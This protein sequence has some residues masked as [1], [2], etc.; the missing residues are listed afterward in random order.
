MSDIAIAECR[1]LGWTRRVRPASLGSI[2][3]KLLRGQEHRTIVATSW[4]LRFYLDPLSNLGSA[5]VERNDYEPQT[6]QILVDALREGDTFVDIGANEGV[7]SCLAAAKV[8]PRGKVVAVEP[9]Q[10]LRDVLEINL[11]LNGTRN[12][13]LV[14]KALSDEPSVI[15]RLFPTMNTGASS[16]VRR[17]RWSRAKQITPTISFSDLLLENAVARADFVKVDVEGYEKEVADSMVPAIRSGKVKTL[18]LDYHASILASRGVRA[19]DIHARLL[20]AGLTPVTD[21]DPA[22]AGYVLYTNPAVG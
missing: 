18:L 16:V 6:R 5:F 8:G 9:Q 13:V 10:R 14:M 11:A 2:V 12:C 22:L 15:L 7:F 19:S 4:G 17:Y 3:A 1:R 20:A 21:G